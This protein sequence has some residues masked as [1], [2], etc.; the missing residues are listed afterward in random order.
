MALAR[1]EIHRWSSCPSLIRGRWSAIHTRLHHCLSY[2][3]TDEGCNL[4][5]FA[6]NAGI[7]FCCLLNDNPIFRKRVRPLL[8]LGFANQARRLTSRAGSLPSASRVGCSGYPRMPDAKML[9]DPVTKGSL[10]LSNSSSRCLEP[11]CSDYGL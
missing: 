11:Y 3:Y 1:L 8:K 4:F 7:I 6:H 2:S 5:T 10:V 9:N